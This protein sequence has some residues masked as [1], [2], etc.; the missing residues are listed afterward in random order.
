MSDFK[1]AGVVIDVVVTAE[2]AEEA[3]EAMD[4]WIERLATEPVGFVAGV[5]PGSERYSGP[6]QVAEGEAAE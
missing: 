1:F 2:G 6:T 3:Q 4:R 5:Q